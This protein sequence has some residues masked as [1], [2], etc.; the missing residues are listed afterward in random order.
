MAAQPIRIEGLR[1]LQRAFALADKMLSRE[2][3]GRLREAA[4]PV[5]VDAE[6]LAR[7]SIKRSKIDWATMRVG[8]TLKSV[9]VAPSRRRTVGTPRR[10]FAPLLLAPM[11]AALE[12]NQAEVVKEVENLLGEVGQAWEQA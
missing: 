1:D 2:L 4:E 9:Y 7:V 11:E 3:T 10:K 5:R 6:S 8:V 12:A